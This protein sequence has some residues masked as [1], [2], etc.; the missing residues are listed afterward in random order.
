MAPTRIVIDGVTFQGNRITVRNGTVTVDGKVQDGTLSGVIEV[1]VVDG[2]LG[3]LDCDASVVCGEV[4]G[5]VSAGGSVQADAVGG[6]VSAGG[7]V[8]CDDVG[9]SVNAGGSVSMA[10]KK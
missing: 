2:V 3:R 4:R 1:R 10:G 9:G 8:Q 6:N 5:D 7:S